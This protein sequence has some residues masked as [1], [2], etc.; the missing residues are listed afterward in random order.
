MS[1]IELSDNELVNIEKIDAQ[2]L[3]YIKIV[4]KLYN[5]LGA[6]FDGETKRLLID[7]K[8]LLRDHF[9]TEEGLMKEYKYVNYFSHKLE[10]DRFF[11]FVDSYFKDISSGKTKLDL[12]FLKSNKRWFFNHFE[13][14]DKKCGEYLLTQGVS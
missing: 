2:H 1:F 12:E 6:K 11:N 13:F 9:D 7:L 5:Q 10:H 8:N 4:N 14:N 3:Q